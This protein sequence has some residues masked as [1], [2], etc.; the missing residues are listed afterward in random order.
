V[1]AG[2][3]CAVWGGRDKIPDTERQ[4]SKHKET[5]LPTQRGR[6][7]FMRDRIPYKERQNALNRETGFPAYRD[8]SRHRAT[9]FLP[10][11]GRILYIER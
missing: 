3:A 7:P 2:K 6:I 1:Y 11:G 9:G 10:Q 5:G 4:D 8:S